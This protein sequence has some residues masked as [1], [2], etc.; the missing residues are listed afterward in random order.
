[1]P[2][3]LLPK[4]G[5]KGIAGGDIGFVGIRKSSDN[6]I[7]KARMANKAKGRGKKVAG[8]RLDPLKT[9]KTKSRS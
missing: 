7:R 1:V 4:Q 6:R 5:K 3:Y 2:D 9:F 8:R